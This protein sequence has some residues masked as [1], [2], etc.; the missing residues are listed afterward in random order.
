MHNT[1]SMEPSQSACTQRTVTGRR[2]Y[3]PLS[4][5]AAWKNASFLNLRSQFFVVFTVLGFR[6]VVCDFVYDII[7]GFHMPFAGSGYNKHA[8]SWC[9][10]ILVSHFLN[11][12]TNFD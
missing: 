4:Y 10:L 8:V 7:K 1:V 11:H 12:F 3:R 6:D 9:L 5:S 2:L